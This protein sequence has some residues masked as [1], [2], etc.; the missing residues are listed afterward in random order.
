MRDYALTRE[1]LRAAIALGRKRRAP[2]RSSG[3]LAAAGRV[4][5]ARTFA[6]MFGGRPIPGGRVLRAVLRPRRRGMVQ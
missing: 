2:A 5:T 3:W 6:W 1:L 4:S